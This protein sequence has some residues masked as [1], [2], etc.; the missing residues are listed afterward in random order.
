[1]KWKTDNRPNEGDR[2]NRVIFA[3]IARRCEDGY[4]RWLTFVEITEECWVDYVHG[5]L[6]WVERGLAR[7]VQP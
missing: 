3:V 6:D 4:T 5:G 2:R 1:M 7:K